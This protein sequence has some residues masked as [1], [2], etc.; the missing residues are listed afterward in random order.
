MIIKVTKI[1]GYHEKVYFMRTYQNIET[2]VDKADSIVFDTMSMNFRA[3]K[4]DQ[5]TYSYGQWFDIN[6]PLFAVY[7]HPNDHPGKLSTV[8]NTSLLVNEDFF[9]IF[10]ERM[11]KQLYNP[12][13]IE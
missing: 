4:I 2:C 11:L 12:H 5:E 9:L 7:F 3:V 13:R 10:L 8:E 6:G 1:S